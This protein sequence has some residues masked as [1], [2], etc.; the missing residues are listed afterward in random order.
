MFGVAERAFHLPVRLIVFLLGLL[1]FLLLLPAAA[2]AQPFGAWSIFN[3]TQGKYFDIASS[4]DLNPTT[5]ITIEAWVALSAT[6]A[7]GQSCR[8]I[9]GKDYLTGYWVGVCGNTLRSY[10]KGISSPRDGG[11]VPNFQWT[12]VAVTY[13]GVNRIH[14]INGEQVAVFA[15]TGPLPTNGS[16]VRIGSDVSWDFQPDG[17]LN[18]I[19]FWNFARSLDQIRGSINVPINTAQPGLVAVWSSGGGNDAVGGHNGINV[20]GIPALT[21]PVTLNCGSSSST[22]ACLNTRF[23]VSIQFRDPNTGTYGTAQVV[24]CPNPDSAAFWFFAPNVWEVLVKIINGCGFNNRYWAFSAAATNVFYRLEVLDVR[25]GVNKIYFNYPG[26]S[27]TAVTDTDA[28]A[29]CP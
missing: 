22:F 1:A 27:A 3:A 23:G 9:I 18:E 25:A 11:T 20:G 2:G 6:N 17:N 10:L 24:S 8:S 5:G 15:E 4:P 21:F 12:H 19:R 16:N 7:Q 29:T 28:F 26:P 13:D 14:Y